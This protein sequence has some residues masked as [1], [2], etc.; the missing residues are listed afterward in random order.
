MNIQWDAEKYSAD[1]SFVHRY[2]NTVMELLTAPEGA[3]VLDLGCGNGALTAALR[4]RGYAAR[5]LDG[6][7]SHLEIAR[8]D[9]P[10]I[11]FLQADAT[12]FSLPEP[13]DAVFSNAVLHWIDRDLQ[14]KLLRCVH[15]ALKPGGEF[16]FEC[17]GFGNNRRIHAA[18]D[19]A[20][21]D[22][23]FRYSMP[24]C[25]PTIGE[26]AALLECAGFRVEY[27]ILFERPTPLKGESGMRDW[28]DMFLRTPFS[29]IADP[30]VQAEIKA[31]AVEQLRREL[32]ADGQWLADYVRL[33]MRAVRL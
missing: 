20:F 30:A 1:F 12:D 27:A 19:R 32:Y 5:G 15:D 23:G 24:F 13:V 6:S 31:A 29:V 7:T 25:F 18:M 3:S 17:G 4:E 22:R 2:G 14:P 11:E 33:R 10:G 26:Y 28:I 9:H 21:A 16:V 8:R